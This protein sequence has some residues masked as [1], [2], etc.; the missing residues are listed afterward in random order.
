M[1]ASR[2]ARAAPSA[3]ATTAPARASSSQALAGSSH[4]RQLRF[5]PLSCRRLAKQI[6][7]A[8]PCAG[9]GDGISDLLARDKK[10]AGLLDSDFEELPAEFVT[11][12]E[13]ERDEKKKKQSSA[14]T[15]S[16]ASSLSS[17]SSS[18]SSSAAA[19]AGPDGTVPAGL[20]GAVPTTCSQAIDAGEVAL[21]SGDAS[22]ALAFFESALDLP[23]SAAVRLSGSPREYSCASDGEAAAALYNMACAYVALGELEPALTCLEGAVEGG[24]SEVAEAA[25]AD[26]DLSALRSSSD[27]FERALRRG[28]DAHLNPAAREGGPAGVLGGL[29]ARLLRRGGGG[30]GGDGGREERRSDREDHAAVVKSF[31][32]LF[33]VSVRRRREGEID[34]SIERDRDGKGER[35][36]EGASQASWWRSGR[37]KKKVEIRSSSHNSDSKAYLPSP[38]AFPPSQPPLFPKLFPSTWA[39]LTRYPPSRGPR[40]PSRRSST[41]AFLAVSQALTRFVFVTSFFRLF[42]L[43]SFRSIKGRASAALLPCSVA[44]KRNSW[45]E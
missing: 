15:S 11:E 24:G 23:G 20:D 17:S 13:E 16:D 30:K 41:R 39:S 28:G 14:S 27:K 43:A 21:R 34:R 18:S 8:P 9:D 25:R 4:L 2:G 31:S 19:Q 22:L 44:S 40:R 32:S 45:L 10:A 7:L 33:K 38:F 29:A 37:R 36:R 5:S 6:V 26:P 12:V 1:L 42:A 3:A 35:K